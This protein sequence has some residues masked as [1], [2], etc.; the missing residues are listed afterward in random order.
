MTPEAQQISRDETDAYNAMCEAW[1][2]WTI[3][4]DKA[5]EQAYTTARDKWEQLRQALIIANF[6]LI[7]G[8]W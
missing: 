8:E 2:N 4:S 7:T 6:G 1:N 3:I 5:Q